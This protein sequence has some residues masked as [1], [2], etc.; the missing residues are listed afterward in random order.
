MRMDCLP[1]PRWTYLDTTAG[2]IQNSDHT[3]S[4][5]AGLVQRTP[6]TDG[7][8]ETKKQKELIDNHTNKEPKA[9]T[10]EWKMD[11]EEREKYMLLAH[12]LPAYPQTQVLRIREDRP[13]VISKP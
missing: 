2:C 10:L 5:I 13:Q 11:E 9:F 7:H 6:P 12:T 4:D 1:I 8:I 3:S